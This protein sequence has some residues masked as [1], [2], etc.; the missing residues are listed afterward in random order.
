[1]IEVCALTKT[2]ALGKRQVQKTGS[3]GETIEAVRDLSFTCRP[4][5]V[6]ALLGPNGAGKTTTLRTI[7][8]MLK[9]SSGT[10]SVCGRDTVRDASNVRASLGF[11]T[12]NTGLYDRLTPLEMVRY[13]ADLNG[14]DP[15]RF[16]ERRSDLFQRLGIES[17]ARRRLGKLSSGMRQKVSIARTIIHDPPVIVFDE[18]TGGLDAIASRSIIQLVREQ[19]DA[20]KTIIFSTH[21]MGEASQLADDLA[22]IHRGSMLYCGPYAHFSSRMQAPTLEDEFVRLVEEAER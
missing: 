14:M 6:F 19:R 2:F 11:L 7:A 4:G 17:F 5:R 20:G 21:R 15:L 13:F 9:P 18:P 10:V 16:E 3:D 8:T 1:M 12:G 22:I